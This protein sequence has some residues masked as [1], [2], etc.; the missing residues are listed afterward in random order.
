MGGGGVSVINLKN[1]KILKKFP[2]QQGK[3]LRV[4]LSPPTGFSGAE[5]QS[6]QKPS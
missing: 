1:Q 6:P 2:F 5:Q 4:P 3:N